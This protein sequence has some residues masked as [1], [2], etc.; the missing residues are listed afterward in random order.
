MFLALSH[1]PAPPGTLLI[2]KSS[3]SLRDSAASDDPASKL[4]QKVRALR[5]DDTVTADRRSLSWLVWLVVIGM[6]AG[7]S[8][9]GWKLWSAR[10]GDDSVGSGASRISN[11]TP[12]RLSVHLLS[13]TH[14]WIVPFVGCEK[15]ITL[16][17]VMRN[18]SRAVLAWGKAP[19]GY[20]VPSDD[21]R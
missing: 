12:P 20:T 13:A 21:F 16:F 15:L 17:G 14:S 18:P 10:T 1:Q 4:S 5:L 6:L 7:G 8:Y 19:P 2:E 9:V 3:Y 11:E